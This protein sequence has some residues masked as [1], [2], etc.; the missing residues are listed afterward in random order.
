VRGSTHLGVERIYGSLI[1][2]SFL[3]SF[4]CRRDRGSNA[5]P[6]AGG[7]KLVCVYS[8]RI[9]LDTI[10][11]CT[12]T[13]PMLLKSFNHIVALDTLMANSKSRDN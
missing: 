5:L 3:P 11:R 10:R 13:H 9:V 1:H 2:L 4:H 7:D 6:W 12:T 8:I